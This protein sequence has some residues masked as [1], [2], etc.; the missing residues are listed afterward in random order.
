MGEGEEEGG[1]GKGSGCHCLR[2]ET[3]LG[4]QQTVTQSSQQGVNPAWNVSS[5]V[6]L[7]INIVS[8]LQPGL[9]AD[10]SP[11]RWVFLVLNRLSRVVCIWSTF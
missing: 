10:I 3:W 11:I 2:G 5:G 9:S 7:T 6:K 4:W 1:G 8:L